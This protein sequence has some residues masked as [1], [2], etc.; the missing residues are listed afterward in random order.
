MPDVDG[1]HPVRR[2]MTGCVEGAAGERGARPAAVGR[3]GVALALP[4]RLPPGR[5]GAGAGPGGGGEERGA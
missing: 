2:A 3:P 1:L 4:E 5:A